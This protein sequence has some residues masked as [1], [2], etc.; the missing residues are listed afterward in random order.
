MLS[1][2]AFRDPL[3]SHSAPKRHIFMLKPVQLAI[4]IRVRLITCQK[5]Y[6]SFGRLVSC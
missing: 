2:A 5:L 4:L 3:E 6:A 1:E